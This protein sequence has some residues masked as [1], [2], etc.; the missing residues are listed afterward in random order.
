MRNPIP[1]LL[2]STL[3][4]AIFFLF[5][6]CKPEPVD[7][8]EPVPA[9]PASEEYQDL[10]TDTL[11]ASN[12]PTAI[13]LVN[14]I[15]PADHGFKATIH[16]GGDIDYYRI[17]C[18]QPGV[19]EVIAIKVPTGLT[20]RLQLYDKDGA[21]VTNGDGTSNE[22]GQPFKFEASCFQ[23][24]YYLKVSASST[25]SDT[26]P[27]EIEVRFDFEDTYEPNNSFYQAKEIQFD[28]VVRGKIRAAGDH[29][30][31]Y[32]QVT[33]AGVLNVRVQPVPSENTIRA[34]IYEE[35][36]TT[37][38][39]TERGDFASQSF[40]FDLSCLPGKYYI[41]IDDLSTQSSSKDFYNLRLTLDTDDVYEPNNSL[42]ESKVISLG[43]TVQAKMRDRH[44]IDYFE[45]DVPSSDTLLFSFFSVPREQR[46]RVTLYDQDQQDITYFTSG[47]GQAKTYELPY[48]GNKIYFSVEDQSNLSGKEFYSFVVDI[49]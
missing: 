5:F 12:L 19:M 17:Y 41:V 23:G 35:L 38:L 15:N 37:K 16:E 20:L 29:D 45:M 46:V 49:L 30:Y 47:T 32:F 28:E 11:D 13:E 14:V 25:Q 9:D 34:I 1:T 31:F 39:I 27:Y 18:Q 40:D 48:W 21:K 24:L 6:S 26:L 22:P 43:D 10:G 36:N 42:F 44:D 33:D 4:A 7:P 3:L 8:N 2:L